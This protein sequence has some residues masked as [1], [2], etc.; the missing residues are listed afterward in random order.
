MERGAAARKSRGAFFV[1]GRGNF[2]NDLSQS[3]TQALLR[4]RNSRLYNPLA[5]HSFG[6]VSRGRNRAAPLPTHLLRIC[7]GALKCPEQ[8]GIPKLAGGQSPTSSRQGVLVCGALRLPH[9]LIC[10][11]LLFP[12]NSPREFCGNPERQES[13][14]SPL[15]QGGLRRGRKSGKYSLSLISGVR[16]EWHDTVSRGRDRAAPLPTHLLR[17]CAGALKRRAL[18]AVSKFA[19]GK[20]PTGL[21]ARKHLL[22]PQEGANNK[23]KR[24][25]GTRVFCSDR[26]FGLP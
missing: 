9:D 14:F 4:M 15:T 2:S 25:V 18:C 12:Q 13:A 19:S 23:E 26:A 17:I 10:L 24:P 16:V 1:G 6:T 3:K 20:E 5:S 7:A 22:T 11:P 21:F 8:W